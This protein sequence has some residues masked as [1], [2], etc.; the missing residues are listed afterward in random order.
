MASN[1]KRFQSKVP[2]I[3]IIKFLNTGNSH[4]QS[5]SVKVVCSNGVLTVYKMVLA[6]IS[7]MLCSAMKG[8]SS[9]DI[10]TIL[11]PDFT[12]D[13]IS[14]YL[15][16][17]CQGQDFSRYTDINKVIGYDIDLVNRTEAVFSV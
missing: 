8:I 7:P 10:E 16:L 13:Q 11:I 4:L 9:E 6:S 12:T 14:K 3:E 1:E 2:L 5:S 15:K 17:V